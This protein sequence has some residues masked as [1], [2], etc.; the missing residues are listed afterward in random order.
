MH[1]YFRVDS[2]RYGGATY[3]FSAN[4]YHWEAAQHACRMVNGN[5]VR[6]NSAA[7]QNFIQTIM[8]KST[9]S[10]KKYLVYGLSTAD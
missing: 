9:C 8:P 3:M 6:I 10:I 1:L 5:L 4:D 2:E 7:E